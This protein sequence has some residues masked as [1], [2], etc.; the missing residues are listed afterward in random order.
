[1]LKPRKSM[2][3]RAADFTRIRSARSGQR[4]FTLVE[5][6]VALAIMAVLAAVL[7]PSLGSKMRDARTSAIAETLQGLA[8]GAA[9]FKKATTHYPGKLSL[10]TTPPLATSTDACANQLST[11]ATLWRGPYVSREMLTTGTS[12]G[13]GVIQ[14]ALTRTTVVSSTY[15]SISVTG[16]EN[17]TAADLETLLDGPSASP[18]TTGTIHSVASGTTTDVSYWIPVNGC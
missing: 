10:L 2:A 11:T 17:E 18:S 7:I 15:L 14:D 8:A 3:T 5:V 6:L 12:M 9:E 13:D 4:G 16:V 1:M